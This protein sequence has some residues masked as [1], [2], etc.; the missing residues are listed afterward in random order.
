MTPPAIEIVVRGVC[1]SD[2]HLLVCRNIA[3]GNI[4]LPGGHVEWGE[5]SPQAL[6][7]EWREELAADCTPGR[8]LGILE[9]RYG[10][11]CELGLY[12][13]CTSPSLS[14]STPPPSPEPHIAFDWL[15]LAAL[16]HSALL[17]SDLRTLL[18][19]W[20]SNPP[21]PSPLWHAPA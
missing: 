4:Y 1:I 13:H 7:R 12:F 3:R 17:P 16:P 18:P 19:L 2:D 9:Q 6:A 15:P 10:D 11:T 8:F 20:L 21:P 5:T 14:S